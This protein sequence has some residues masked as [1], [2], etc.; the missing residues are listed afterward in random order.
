MMFCSVSDKGKQRELNEDYYYLPRPGERFCAVADGMGGHL[1]GEVASRIAIESLAEELRK[2]FS[3]PEEAMK[4]AFETA[5]AQV[6]LQAEKSDSTRGMGTTLTALLFTD[7]AAVL[8]HIGDSRLY[9]LRGGAFTQLSTDH[10]FVEGLVRDGVISREE[11]RVH[12]RRNLITRCIGQKS[13]V[14]P[15]IMPLDAQEGDLYLLC[16]DGLTTMLTDDEILRCL[17]QSDKSLQQK[18]EAL[19]LWALRRGGED[20][21]TVVAVGGE[22][23]A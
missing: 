22:I 15:E 3:D 12:P 19:R 2:P 10:S 11:A 20:N 1:S 6:L 13:E 7:G 5:N 9:R 8:G 18:L 14:E 16:S 23:D 21:V 17:M 4:R